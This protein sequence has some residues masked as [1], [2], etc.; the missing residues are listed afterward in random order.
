MCWSLRLRFSAFADV[1]AIV[2]KYVR[3]EQNVKGNLA[4]E[5]ACG[6]RPDV[7]RAPGHRVATG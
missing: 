5:R 7:F 6:A 1:R 4:P 2:F 3:F